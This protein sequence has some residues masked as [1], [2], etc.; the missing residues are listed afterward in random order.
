[1]KRPGGFIVIAVLALLWNLLGDAAYL[2]QVS[3]D[4]EA[5]A[6][7]DPYQAKIFSEMPQWVWAAYAVAVWVGTLAAIMLLLRKALAVPLYTVSLVA[8]LVQFSYSFFMTDLLAVKGWQAAIFPAFIIVLVVAQ[9]LY[10]RAMK[11]RGVLR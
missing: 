3:M 1:M 9:L 8:V 2:A 11:A 4:T 10:A 5:L 6:K 7:S